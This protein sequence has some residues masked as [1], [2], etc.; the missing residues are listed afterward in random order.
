MKLSINGRV[1]KRQD[2]EVSAPRLVECNE[3]FQRLEEY[4]SVLT[5]AES[6]P[7]PADPPE[8]VEPLPSISETQEKAEKIL[9][10]AQTAAQEILAKAQEDARQALA[11][12]RE[13]ADRLRE[14]VART[15]QTEIYPAAQAE[16]YKIGLE[17]GEAEGKRLTQRAN[18]LFQLAQRAFQEEYAKVDAELLHL[19]LKIAERIIRSTLTLEPQR[20]MNIIR[21][22]TLLPQERQGWRLHVSPGDAYLLEDDHFP[23][24]GVIDESLSSGDCYLEC[25]EGI[26]DAR[27]EAQLNKLENALREELEHGS[28][29]FVGSDSGTN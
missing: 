18:Q 3:G 17:A 11:Q 14:E 2:V 21:S 23:C 12:A 16:G 22:L 8:W 29:E 9:A 26:F 20:L 7:I 5:V 4:L 27:V 25:Q 28:M 6:V 24:P 1:V 10:E 13:E 19:A 15:A